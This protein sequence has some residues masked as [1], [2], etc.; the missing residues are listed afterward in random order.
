[1]E[2]QQFKRLVSARLGGGLQGARSGEVIGDRNVRSS[3]AAPTRPGTAA[4]TRRRHDRD[5]SDADLAIWDPQRTVEI[6]DATSHDAAGYCP[7]VGL[8][9]TGW[10]TTMISC[11]E[12][13]VD[14]RTSRGARPLSPSRC[15]RRREAGRPAHPRDKPCAQLRRRSARSRAP[16]PRAGKSTTMRALHQH[17]EKERCRLRT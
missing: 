5:G 16:W 4:C 17:A 3:S 1:L 13:I 10:P 11:G 2:A 9:I 6:T 7:Y 8:T 14:R 15:R 12:V